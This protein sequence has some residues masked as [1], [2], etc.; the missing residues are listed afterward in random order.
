MHPESKCFF[1]FLSTL[2]T[3][4]GRHLSIV[5][6]LVVHP[7]LVVKKTFVTERTDKP[8]LSCMDDDVSPQTS[9]VKKRLV[10]SFHVKCCI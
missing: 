8:F 10:G 3:L 7:C 5:P 1:E 6:F 4:I 2:T 9:S